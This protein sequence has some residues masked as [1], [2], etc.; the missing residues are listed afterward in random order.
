MGGRPNKFH[1]GCDFQRDSDGT[2]AFGPKS[3][4]NKLMG[5]YR[6]SFGCCKQKEYWSR[7]E[8]KDHTELNNSKFM[9][10]EGIVQAIIGADQWDFSMGPFDTDAAIMTMSHLRTSP[11]QEKLGR[12]KRIY[13]YLKCFKDEP[14]K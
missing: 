8:P 6:L 12:I 3:F 2:S 10:V 1:L 9:N 13:G 4:I 7:L 11:Q 14:S 5:Y